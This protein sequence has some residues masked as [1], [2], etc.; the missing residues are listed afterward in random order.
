MYGQGGMGQPMYPGA[1]HR[2]VGG[3][4]YSAGGGF[5]QAGGVGMQNNHG[6][7]GSAYSTKDD[8]RKPAKDTLAVAIRWLKTRSDKEKMLFAVGAGILVR[9][10]LR[11]RGGVR[12]VCWWFGERVGRRELAREGSDSWAG[13]G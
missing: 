8:S 7:M 9:M 5:Q 11:R 2:S 10:M 6:S 1:G 4:P 3:G 12:N 13:F